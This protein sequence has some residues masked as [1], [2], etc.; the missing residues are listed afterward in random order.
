MSDTIPTIKVI[1]KNGGRKIIINECDFD[2]SLHASLSDFQAVSSEPTQSTGVV[3][4]A[5][6]NGS[7]T[8]VAKPTRRRRATK[9]SEG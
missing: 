2:E 4:K 7:E 1:R 5:A 3:E 6:E 9:G 8:V